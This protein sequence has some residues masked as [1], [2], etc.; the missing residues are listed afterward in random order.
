M[1][2]DIHGV[3]TQRIQERRIRAMARQEIDIQRAF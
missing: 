2:S 1:T 3:W